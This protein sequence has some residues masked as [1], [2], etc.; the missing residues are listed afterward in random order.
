MITNMLSIDVED[1][2]Q[3]SAFEQISPPESWGQ[4]E[5][6]VE[7]NTE[8]ILL[9]FDEFGVKATFFTLGWVA[10]RCPGLVRRIA[11]AGHEIAS[12]G[13]GHRR[14]YLQSRQV[15]RDDI[16]RSKAV[17][18]DCSGTAV[19][20]YRA[21]S[22]SIGLNSLWAFDELMAA[23][24]DYDSS[25]CPVKHDFY[26]IPHWPR[27]PFCVSRQGDGDWL[28]GLGE[29]QCHHFWEVPVSTLHLAGRNIP[30]AG[31]GYFRLYPYRFSRWGLRR[32]NEQEVKP[33][34]FYLHPWELD[35][36]QP[37][38]LGAGMKSRVRHYLN[39]HKTESR[40]RRL[41]G[42]FLFGTIREFQSGLKH[43][44]GGKVVQYGF[45]SS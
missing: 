30:I 11:D 15:F 7:A 31:G 34:L 43:T 3:V 13:Y 35:P 42:D 40:L 29:G 9:L 1:Y 12:H 20:G 21:P 33:F 10:Q 37:R 28:P 17:L 14:V 5:L 27:F 24:Y 25:V 41:L 26:G 36:N 22:F 45:A 23:G 16:R 6:R 18:E 19:L 8:R 32:I 39:L 44:D 4:R 38:I 2:F